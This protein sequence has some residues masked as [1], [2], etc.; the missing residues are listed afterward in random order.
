M[1][2]LDTLAYLRHENGR[3]VRNHDAVIPGQE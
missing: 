3:V 2:V 1:P